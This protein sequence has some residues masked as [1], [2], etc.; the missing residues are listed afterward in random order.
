MNVL[1][2]VIAWPIALFPFVAPP[3]LVVLLLVPRSRRWMLARL[4]RR[5]RPR[6]VK[7]MPAPARPA[8]P[9]CP[10]CRMTADARLDLCG[11]CGARLPVH[12]EW[13]P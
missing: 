6:H 4:R 12:A 10:Y 5:E 11:N 3:A 7:P 9:R 2:E 13:A 1:I 8:V